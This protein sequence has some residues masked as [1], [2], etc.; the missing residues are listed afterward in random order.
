[1]GSP[2]IRSFF[3]VLAA[4][5]LSLQT[6]CD[7]ATPDSARAAASG[8]G[9]I[10][11]RVTYTGPAD[12][13]IIPGSPQVPDESIVTGPH[14]GLKNVIVYLKD[15]PAATFTLKTPIVLDQIKTVY[16]PH[17]IAVQTGQTLTLKSSDATLHNVHLKALAN[18]D[19]NYGFPAPGAKDVQFMA[20]E[21]PFPVKCDVHPWMS[22]WIAVFDHP[23]FAVTGDDGSFTIP[24][25]PPGEYT[26]V[27]W[28]EV[29]PEQEQQITVTAT[30]TTEADF[31]FNAP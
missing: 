12:L 18:P 6:A 5:A 11:G 16:V 9:I 24:H 25:V 28:Q 19:V 13:K 31:S 29:L 23:W 14:A 22:A 27:A 3:F 7:R 17:V 21:A 15:A 20:A 8:E 30:G 2:N 10:K 26:V 1:M 4:L